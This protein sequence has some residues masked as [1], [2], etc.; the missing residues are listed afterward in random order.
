M[1]R[2]SFAV[3]AWLAGMSA[4]TAFD[5]P[6]RKPGLWEL[7]MSFPGRNLAA[8]AMKQCT[9]AT[10][11][12]LMN[13]NFGASNE[14]NC[15]KQDV[16]KTASGLVIDSVCTFA[17]ATTTSHS[18]MTGSFDSAYTVE[19][20]STREGGPPMPGLKPGAETH[21]KI[22]A[23]W[24]G[25]CSNGQKPGDVIMANGMKMNVFDVQKMQRATPPR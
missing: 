18:V 12:K 9:D 22:D 15:S 3:I 5:L 21:M 6:M 1:H 20:T 10:S 13:M 17:G 11:D 25:P 7:S 2:A 4:G 14:M 16:T 8:Q 24:L 23:K 19:V